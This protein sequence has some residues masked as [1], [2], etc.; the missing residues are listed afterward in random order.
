M[1]EHE[2]VYEAN[3]YQK[4]YVKSTKVVDV[5]DKQYAAG[6]LSTKANIIQRTSNIDQEK[7]SFRDN[8]HCIRV[9]KFCS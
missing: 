3:K 7:V 1:R 2:K 4:S 5:N 8:V 6:L 9:Y